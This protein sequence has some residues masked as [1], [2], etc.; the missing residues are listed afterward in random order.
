[1]RSHINSYKLQVGFY[2]KIKRSRVSRDLLGL[3]GG[4]VE[5]RQLLVDVGFWSLKELKVGVA[6]CFTA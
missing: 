5:L 6:F 2:R 4:C 1:M 3:D